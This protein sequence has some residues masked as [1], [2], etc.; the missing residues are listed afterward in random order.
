MQALISSNPSA[1]RNAIA[2]V[3]KIAAIV[4]I[5][6]STDFC[7]ART[8]GSLDVKV[9]LRTLSMTSSCL[10]IIVSRVSITVWVR[11]LIKSVLCLLQS[12]ESIFV[13][14]KGRTI[15]IVSPSFSSKR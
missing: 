13:S 12:S 4:T 3:A 1:V 11:L 14:F 9:Y 2:R 6:I 10:A 15:L 5:I 8:K 7:V